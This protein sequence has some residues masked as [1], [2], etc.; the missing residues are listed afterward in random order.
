VTGVA[1][2]FELVLQNLIGNAIKFRAP[3]PLRI[4]VSARRDGAA[5]VF[6]VRDNGIGIARRHFGTVFEM[7]QRLGASDHSG[8]GIGLTICRKIVERQGGRI[9]LDSE[10]GAGTTFHF[11]IPA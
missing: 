6:S 4:H 1:T 3:R 8:T 7:F 10:E 11:T 5:W 2:L 9:W